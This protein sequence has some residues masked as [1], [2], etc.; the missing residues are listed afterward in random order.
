MK[1]ERNKFLAIALGVNISACAAPKPPDAQPAQQELTAPRAKT[2]TPSLV[3]TSQNSTKAEGSKH[4]TTDECLERNK[5]GECVARDPYEDDET[6]IPLKTLEGFFDM[7]VEHDSNDECIKWEE[8]ADCIEVD[9]DD[10]CVA[11]HPS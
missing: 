9:E 5:D 3:N 4:G 2:A 10:K 1:M 11:R 8:V 6:Y 7:C